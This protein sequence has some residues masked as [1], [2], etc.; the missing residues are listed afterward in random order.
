ML[1]DILYR[2]TRIKQGERCK[3]RFDIA[4]WNVNERFNLNLPRTNNDVE[5]WHSRI[6]PD[7]RQNLTVGKVIELFRQEQSYMESNLVQLF[8]GTVL[9]KKEEKR[10]RKRS[11][12]K[13]CLEL[14]DKE[15]VS[16]H[17]NGLS[18][19]LSDN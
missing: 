12:Y 6:K 11:K 9:K 1:Y 7:A 19:L 2:E 13:T 17:L 10:F 15:T 5:S 16:F 4:L 8:K 14:Y 18:N 3:P